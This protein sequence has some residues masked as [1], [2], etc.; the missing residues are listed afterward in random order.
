PGHTI[1]DDAA[2]QV[3]TGNQ[4][5]E[6][7][8][9]SPDGRWLVF[10]SDRRGNADIYRQRLDQPNAGPDQLTTDSANDYGPA[11]SPD[12]REIVFHSLRSGNRDLWVMS[13]D[14]SSPRQITHAPFDEYSGAWLPDGRSVMYY[15][16]S[17][18]TF[19]L[20]KVSRDSA[21]NWGAPKLVLADVP[22][23]IAASPNMGVLVGTHAGVLSLIDTTTWTATPLPGPVETTQGARGALLTAD[24]S[25]VYYRGREPD[26]RLSLI[27]VHLN[28][29]RPDTLVRPR[30]ASRAALR[31]D[32]TTDGKRFFFTI[33]KYEGDIWTV[34]V[35]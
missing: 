8:S 15:V 28:G 24:R 13:I 5:I 31:A 23:A 19:W 11:V 10:D 3:T 9:L 25:V 30:D 16:D 35:K 1:T 4:V 32:W 26:G 21:G 17:V 29:T 22:G 14:G 33:N 18:G 7:V 34:E 6:R 27:R 2:V 12:G 20:G